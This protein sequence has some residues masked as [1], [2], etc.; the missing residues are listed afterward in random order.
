YES[1]LGDGWEDIEV[2]NNPPEIREAALKMGV[3]IVWFALT[4]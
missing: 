1:D 2:H 3:N 4:Q